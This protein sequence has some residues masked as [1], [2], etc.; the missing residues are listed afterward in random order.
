VEEGARKEI[1]YL[2][3]DPGERRRETKDTKVKKVKK[4]NSTRN[5]F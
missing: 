3:P 2:M 4:C 1:L 5:I